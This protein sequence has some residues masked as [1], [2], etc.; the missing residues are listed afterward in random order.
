MANTVH[1]LFPLL[2]RSGSI[3]GVQTENRIVMA[4]MIP[5]VPVGSEAYRAWYEDRARGGVG[6]IISGALIPYDLLRDDF[7][8]LLQPAVDAV[9]TA[10]VP[11]VTQLLQPDATE[12]GE[13]FAP[14]AAAD[15]REATAAEIAAIPDQ[16][17]RAARRC[18]QLGFSGVEIHHAF[19]YFLAQMFSP[20]ANYRTDQY[21]GSFDNRMRLPQDIL[22][23]VRAEVGDA[24][25]IVLRHTAEQSGGFTM[26]DSTDFLGRMAEA[27]LD[28][29]HIAPSTRG[30]DHADLAAEVRA[31]VGAP[32]IAVGGM[33]DPH[34]AEAALREGKCDFCALARQLIADP[35]W[36]SKVREGRRDEIVAYEG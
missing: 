12:S 17:A 35:Q 22:A 28:A 31:A 9:R 6:L 20:L 33:E 16:F 8:E 10:G 30:T 11:F 3:G 1:D 32:V 29:V 19:G 15:A 27:G 4:P 25:A 14:S 24:F 5:R 2:F 26:A 23:A 36:P 13:R 34:R 21:G 7:C 18:Q